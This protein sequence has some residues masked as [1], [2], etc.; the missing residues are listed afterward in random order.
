MQKE[1][2]KNFKGKTIRFYGHEEDG[3]Y[4]GHAYCPWCSVKKEVHRK[5]SFRRAANLAF[6]LIETHWKISHKE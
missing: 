4:A 5:A 3:S 1:V 6:E 2:K